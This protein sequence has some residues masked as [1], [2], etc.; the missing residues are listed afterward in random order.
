ML[1]STNS[2]PELKGAD[3]Q[4]RSNRFLFLFG[5]QKV[6]TRS[7][8]FGRMWG[9]WCVSG[10]MKIPQ[11]SG[12]GSVCGPTLR[13]FCQHQLCDIYSLLPYVPGK[14]LAAAPS[15]LRVQVTKKASLQYQQNPNG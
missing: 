4:G 1:M 14:P 2:A 9:G 11:P 3:G 15:A 6:L 10:L 7:L 13:V 8:R 5:T 12:R